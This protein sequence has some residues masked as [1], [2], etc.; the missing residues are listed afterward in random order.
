MVVGGC[1]HIY[2]KTRGRCR[3]TERVCVCLCAVLKYESQKRGQRESNKSLSSK[4]IKLAHTHTHCGPSL[5][6]SQFLSTLSLSPLHHTL[7]LHPPLGAQSQGSWFAPLCLRAASVVCACYLGLLQHAT[8]S[9]PRAQTQ[10][11]QPER[12]TETSS[13]RERHTVTGRKAQSEEKQQDQAARISRVEEFQPGGFSGV[14]AAG[15]V[16]VFS[17]VT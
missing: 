1:S 10:P 16:A 15:V 17:D 14:V 3:I 6:P 12:E 4:Q 8:S 2:C 9:S 7:S 11:S 5:W 13:V